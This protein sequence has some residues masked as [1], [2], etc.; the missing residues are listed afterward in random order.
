MTRDD[1]DRA[2]KWAREEE[3]DRVGHAVGETYI[4]LFELAMA[5]RFIINLWLN[6]GVR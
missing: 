4:G 6:A 3:G 2:N 5:P 1:E